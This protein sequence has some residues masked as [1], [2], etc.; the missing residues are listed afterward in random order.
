MSRIGRLTNAVT[1]HSRI[2]IAALLVLTVL[3]GSGAGM[4]DESASIDQYVGDS[5]AS[6][7]FD[8]ANRNFSTGAENATYVQVVVRGENVLSKDALLETLRLQQAFREN[9]TVGPTLADGNDET[10]GQ[11]TIGVA[12]VV[13]TRAALQ[14]RAPDANAQP[15]TLQEQ[16]DRLESMNATEVDRIVATVLDPE[17]P[18]SA[19]VLAFMPGNYD[20]GSTTANATMVVV[21][22]QS[23]QGVILDADRAPREIVDSQLAM[24]SIANRQAETGDLDL[25]VYGI[26]LMGEEINWSME[27]SMAVVGPLALLFVLL[28]LIVAYRD[29]VDVVLGLVGIGVVLLWTFGIM[30]W[31]GIEFNQVMIAVPVL[32]IGL[33][34]DYALHTV[35]RYRERRA[36]EG[37]TGESVRDS[38]GASLAHVGLAL[39]MVTVTTAIGF[40]AN[41]ASRV[42][43]IQDFGIASAI[44]IASTLLVFG[45][46]TPALKVEI[47]AVLERRGVDRTRPAFGT[48]GTRLSRALSVGA[49][50]ARKAPLLVVLLAVLVSGA[51]AYGAMQVE[52][53]FDT[54]DFLAEDPPDWMDEAPEPFAPRDYTVKRN[55]A[56]LNDHF[57]RQDLQVHVLVRGD[58]TDPATLQRL[59]RAEDRAARSEITGTL[60]NGEP[61]IRSP[62]SVMRQVGARNE[63]FGETFAAADAD[64][65]GVPDRNLANVYDALF[66]AAPEQAAEVLHRTEDGEIR[67]LRTTIMTNGA[68]SDGKVTDET[69]A[70]ADSIAGDGVSATATGR[71][72]LYE[73][74]SERLLETVGTT[75]LVTLV[76]VFAFLAVAYRVTSGSATLGVLT[77]V[78]VLLN[79][80]WIL[81]TMYLLGYDFNG[82]TGMITSL[83]IGLGIDYSIHVSERYTLELERTGDVGAALHAAVTGTGGAL[84]G[85]AVTTASGFGVLA[86]ALLPGLQQFGVITA[87]TIV[88]AFLASVLVLPSFL[89][90]WT[91]Y[92]GPG[93]G[94]AGDEESTTTA[95]TSAAGS[96]GD[97]KA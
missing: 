9:R 49:T 62:L 85:S 27:D 12:T 28:A 42:G 6:R 64:G 86:F 22:Q 41:L 30:G 21:V 44:G 70:I 77:L 55:L 38:M 79:V 53:S 52:T 48:G 76:A 10:E 43:Q 50:A 87:L 82:L 73:I 90:V 5:D 46:L 37:A 97:S 59:D 11:A 81:G 31:L 71:P 66:A 40:L 32:L 69:R 56:Y 75:L 94:L 45:L 63:S 93:V 16:I 3:V 74:I 1:G 57:P 36:A 4:V 78:P 91:R 88:Y 83:T 17:T 68:V 80:T 33:S 51:G 24:Q 65:N 72:V 35:M 15:P 39:G 84:L 92:F 58:L 67:A 34:I 60:P 20:P 54:A 7:A 23:D 18:G 14:T 47:D 61:R 26:G 2:V 29:V 95:S 13:A 19:E 96:P 25:L 8:Y 89:V